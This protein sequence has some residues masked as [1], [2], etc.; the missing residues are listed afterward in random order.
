M[1]N[2][3][4]STYSS[5]KLDVGELSLN[6]FSKAANLANNFVLTLSLINPPK[7]NLTTSGRSDT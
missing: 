6:T 2:F 7:V 4:P 5:I 1:N 3:R